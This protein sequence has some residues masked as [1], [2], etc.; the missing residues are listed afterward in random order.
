M[1]RPMG[2]PFRVKPQG[3][4]RPQRSRMFPMAVLRRYSRLRWLYVS[5][6]AAMGA[7]GGA[8]LMG[9]GAV[10]AAIAS[11]DESTLRGL[12]LQC[13]VISQH[14]VPETS[15]PSPLRAGTR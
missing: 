7:V 3:R 15:L 12:A 5:R 8:G 9:A 2:S 11:V 13:R 6:L 10:K 4:E 1:R 14:A